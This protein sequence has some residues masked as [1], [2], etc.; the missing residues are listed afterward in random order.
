MI[1]A[2]TSEVGADELA[3]AAELVARTALEITPEERVLVLFDR[4]SKQIASALITATR[5]RGAKIFAVDLDRLGQRPLS[6]LDD[7]V[8]HELSRASA[9]VF[10]ARALREELGMRQQ[11]LHL[12]KRHGLRHAHMP[13]VSTL[14]FARGQRIDYAKVGNFGRRLA[15]K[16]RQARR[17]E[18]ESTA[19]TALVVELGDDCRWFEQL[20]RLAPGRW[21][22]LPAGALYTSPL[23]VNGVFVADASV[24][25]Y[26]GRREG[27]LR[28]K[29]LKL[30]IEDGRV[31]AASAPEAPALAADVERMLS[32]GPGS[33]RVGLVAV[34]VNYGIHEPTGEALVDQ[35]LPGLH[36]GIGDPAAQVTGASWTAPTSFAA[37]GAGATVV[38]QSVPVIVRGKLLTPA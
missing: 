10:V 35:N 34:G 27:N 5:S 36:L 32:F 18:V 2:W 30:F 26:F 3:R 6:V 8:T 1:G 9:S 24:G 12:V 31:R 17:L 13:D 11:V 28:D 20:G 15:D 23:R 21:G 25:E 14:A 29:P 33:D 38:V 16:L 4:Q 19:G 37:C 7:W 22:N